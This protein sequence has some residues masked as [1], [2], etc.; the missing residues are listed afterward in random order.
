VCACM[1]V[2]VHACVVSCVEHQKGRPS[3]SMLGDYMSNQ[4]E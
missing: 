1:L 2:S 4:K 3:F